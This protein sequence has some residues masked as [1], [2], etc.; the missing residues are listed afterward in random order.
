MRAFPCHTTRHAG[1]HRAVHEA[2]P[3]SQCW[4]ERL[5]SPSSSK[6]PGIATF[7]GFILDMAHGPFRDAA[8]GLTSFS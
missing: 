4:F 1:P 2:L 3:T 8:K 6:K 5:K 7:I